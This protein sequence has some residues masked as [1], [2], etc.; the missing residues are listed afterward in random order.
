MNLEDL[1]RCRDCERPMSPHTNH[2][3]GTLKHKGRGLCMADYSRRARKAKLPGPTRAWRRQGDV[4]TVWQQSGH[5]RVRAAY[6]LGMS[7]NTLDRAI[8][9]WKKRNP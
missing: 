7:R 1:P 6:A 2:I 4:I 3:P 9:R 5:N 8:A